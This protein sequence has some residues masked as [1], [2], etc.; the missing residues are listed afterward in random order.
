MRSLSLSGSYHILSILTPTLS[1]ALIL[2]AKVI[3]TGVIGFRVYTY[4]RYRV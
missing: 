3:L 1:L 2:L 4:R